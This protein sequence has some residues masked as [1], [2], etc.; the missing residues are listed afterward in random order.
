MNTLIFDCEVDAT[1]DL[2]LR[3]PPTVKP[4]RHRISLVVDPPE[5]ADAE[6][7]IVPIPDSIPPR[8]ALWSQL[9]ALRSQAEK[10][11]ELPAS[12]PVGSGVRVTPEPVVHD[13]L[14][15][16]YQ[17]RTELGRKLIELRRAYI[18]NGGKLM[19]QDEI[20]DYVRQNRGEAVDD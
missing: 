7:P 10:E 9:A 1:G 8:T 11:G 17:P 14:V 15:D 4:G 2:V 6:P 18:Q 19:T 13:P 5:S 20:L 16:D 3:L 12:L